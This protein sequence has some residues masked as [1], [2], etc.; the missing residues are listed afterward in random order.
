MKQRPI[1]KRLWAVFCRTTQSLST[2]ESVLRQSPLFL[3]FHSFI[4]H[5]HPSYIS[6]SMEQLHILRQRTTSATKQLFRG[7][8][9][10]DEPEFL[11]EDGTNAF[12]TFANGPCAGY[13]AI[14]THTFAEQAELIESLRSSNEKANDQFKV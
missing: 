8:P 10:T 7:P 6:I 5:Q 9:D 2:S 1:F 11:P 14:L 12:N 4:L 13:V 3:F